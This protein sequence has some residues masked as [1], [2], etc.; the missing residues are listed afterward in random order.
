MRMHTRILV[1]FLPSIAGEWYCVDRT[2]NG[3]N[4]VCDLMRWYN[5]HSPSHT[6][7]HTNTY[8][9]ENDREWEKRHRRHA[10]AQTHRHNHMAASTSTRS[11]W[12]VLF[13]ALCKAHT[14]TTISESTF[15]MLPLR[16]C[17]QQLGPP[18]ERRQQT[19]A[20]TTHEQI[21]IMPIN[22]CIYTSAIHRC[23][24]DARIAGVYPQWGEWWWQQWQQHQQN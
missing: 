19:N 6:H 15:N 17:V 20:A 3:K 8:A 12:V 2:A 18:M 4:S 5:T 21:I 16:Y 1:S 13:L 22:V 7:A 24:V 14:G 23:A 10:S 11:R 9:M